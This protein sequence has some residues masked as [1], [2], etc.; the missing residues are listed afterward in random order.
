MNQAAINI[1][2]YAKTTQKQD[3]L[4]YLAIY[5]SITRKEAFDQLGICELSS[6]IGELERDGYVIPRSPKKGQAPNGRK[7]VVTEYFAPT[8]LP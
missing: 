2:D 8:E 1:V 7:W 3:L 4:H 5:G 6:R